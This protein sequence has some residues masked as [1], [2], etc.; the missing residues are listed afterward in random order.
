M[1]IGIRSGIWFAA[2]LMVGGCSHASVRHRVETAHAAALAR[3]EVVLVYDLAFTDADV[4]PDRAPLKRLV[5]HVSGGSQ[6]QRADQIGQGV[7]NAFADDLVEGL[8]ALGYDAQRATLDTPVTSRALL[9]S[10]KFVNVDEGNR[11]RRL[12]IGFG[13][14]GSSLDADVDVHY[15]VQNEPIKLTEFT[16]HAD[17]GHMPGAAATMGVGAAAQASAAGMVVANAAI[18]GVKEH[19][20]GAERLAGESAKKTVA[21]LADYFTQQ[22]WTP[23]GATHRIED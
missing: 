12:V 6:T 1:K 5:A 2:A 10:G 3:P 4:Q 7:A 16:A 19:R 13:A 18:G 21:Y 22:G 14:G 20:S 8:R 17:S 15:V 9:V 11:L 23:P